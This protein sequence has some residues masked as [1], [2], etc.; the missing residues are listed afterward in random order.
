MEQVACRPGSPEPI[1]QWDSI[2]KY[3]RHTVLPFMI[4]VV[5]IKNRLPL[6]CFDIHLNAEIS[7]YVQPPKKNTTV[8][9][10]SLR[11]PDD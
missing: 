6:V 9:A 5:A 4:P 7:V 10:E 2:R 8:V 11:P 1:C 3:R